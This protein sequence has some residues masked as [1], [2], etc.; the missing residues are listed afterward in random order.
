MRITVYDADDCIPKL[1][2]ICITA[3]ESILFLL[4]AHTEEAIKK[5][6]KNPSSNPRNHFFYMKS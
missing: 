3:N 5:K 4:V 6:K 2:I 1:Y